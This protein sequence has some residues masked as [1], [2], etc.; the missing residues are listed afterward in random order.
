MSLPPGCYLAWDLHAVKAEAD[1][2]ESLSVR[3]P[4]YG[5]AADAAPAGEVVDAASVA[6]LLG[7]AERARRG[8]LPQDLIALLCAG[9]L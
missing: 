2:Q 3:R 6:L 5:K 9:A 7:A 1:P 8:Q 4:P